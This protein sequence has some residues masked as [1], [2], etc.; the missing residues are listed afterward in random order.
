MTKSDRLGELADVTE[1]IEA[2]ASLFVI[3]R[4]LLR[5]VIVVT[6]RPGVIAAQIVHVEIFLDRSVPKIVETVEA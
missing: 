6:E 5:P 1:S 4:P 2:L 3:V